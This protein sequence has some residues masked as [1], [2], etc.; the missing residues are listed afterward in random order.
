MKVSTLIEKL[1]E[2]DPDQHIAS[3]YWSYKELD[4]AFFYM[5][6]YDWIALTDYEKNEILDAFHNSHKP[7]IGFRALQREII[8]YIQTNLE[9]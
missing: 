8:K 5:D 2:L 7:S 3:L 4:D 1:Q 6:D 9:P